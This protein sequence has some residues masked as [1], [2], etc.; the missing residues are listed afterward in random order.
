M[1]VVVSHVSLLKILVSHEDD[2]M[3]KKSS[4]L[5]HVLDAAGPWNKTTKS[6]TLNQKNTLNT[7]CLPN[8]LPTHNQWSFQQ[9]KMIIVITFQQTIQSK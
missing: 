7:K 4:K 9:G 1:K 6:W 3:C 5:C 8:R 2:S